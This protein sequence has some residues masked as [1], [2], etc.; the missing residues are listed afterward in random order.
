MHEADRSWTTVLVRFA[1]APPVL[2]IDL[3]PSPVR[4]V[5]S[6][7]FALFDDMRH[8]RQC[9]YRQSAKKPQ[10]RASTLMRR[11]RIFQKRKY[12]SAKLR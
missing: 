10:S 5:Y 12:E 9:Y 6:H 11:R 1:V 3:S 2:T 8:K 4:Q 7:D